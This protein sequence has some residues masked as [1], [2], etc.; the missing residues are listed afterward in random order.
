[1]VTETNESYEALA[2]E[3][4][5]NPSKLAAIR[6]KLAANRLTTPLFDTERYTRDFEA[7]LGDMILTNL[8]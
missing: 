7:L 3:L 1:L 6:E 2:L 8:R 5:T 4:A